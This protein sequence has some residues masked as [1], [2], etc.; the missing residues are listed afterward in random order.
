MPHLW[1]IANGHASPSSWQTGWCAS[2]LLQN[3][4]D[5]IA[6]NHWYQGC[7]TPPWSSQENTTFHPSTW[8]Q[9]ILHPFLL[10]LG[11]HPSWWG[12]QV[13]GIHPK[14]ALLVWWLLQDISL[15]HKSPIQNKHLSALHKASADIMTLI[16]TPPKNNVR[17]TVIMSD[18]D[19]TYNC[20]TNDWMG[21]FIDE[22]D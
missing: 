20:I 15:Q 4:E 12:R 3:K 21:D 11:M 13:T 18:L 5:A 1:G 7:H 17:L 8:P 2:S 16:N 6:L 19:V 14:V 22:M 10:C 9:E